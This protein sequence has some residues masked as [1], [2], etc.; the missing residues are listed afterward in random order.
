MAD[1]TL[2]IADWLQG[3][4][5]STR[6]GTA[7]PTAEID[8]PISQRVAKVVHAGL[9]GGVFLFVGVLAAMR[10]AVDVSLPADVAEIIRYV[11]LGQLFV[12]GILVGKLRRRIPLLQGGEAPAL[13]WAANGSR[14]VITWAT[15]E[16]TAIIG[17]VFW[18]LTGDPVMLVVSL[19]AAVLLFRL[20]PA[21]WTTGVQ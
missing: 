19:A 15:A 7:M 6:E 5:T 21:S 18:L 1:C 4:D 11:G 14:V 13:W 17:G 2:Q 16:G 8:Q 10:Q 9:M 3:A 20:R 12:I